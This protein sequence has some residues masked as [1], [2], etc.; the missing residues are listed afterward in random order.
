M[1]HCASFELDTSQALVMGVLNL[2]P[3]SF[4]NDGLFRNVDAACEQARRMVAEGASIIDVGG[5]STRPGSSEVALSEELARVV[6]VVRILANEGMV[7]SIDTRH[8]EVAA[9]CVELG[10]AI[11]NDVTGFTQGAMIALAQDTDVGCVIMHMQGEPKT[12]Q[13][14][15]EY[16]DVVSEVEG[17]L[18][19]Q[20]SMLE[21]E[22]VAPGRI[23]IDPGPGFGKDFDHNRALLCATRRLSAHGYPLLAAWSR[24]R[25]VGKL[26][27]V[28]QPS[29]RVIGSVVA[30]LYAVSQG[31]HVV[32]VHDVAA[33]VQALAAWRGIHAEGP[34]GL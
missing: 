5:E 7:V 2:T 13:E 19:S 16:D 24:K 30:A 12:M 31:A 28:E 29:E 27:G 15:P 34:D 1:W 18:L 20:A 25:F 21:R 6:P 22:G 17:Y 32:R 3:D 8:A 23:C 4:S 10:A 14:A 11:V 26:T 9:A 33:T